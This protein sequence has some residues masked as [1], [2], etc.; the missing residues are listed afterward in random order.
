MFEQILNSA[1]RTQEEFAELEENGWSKAEIEKYKRGYSNG[2][3]SIVSELR[4]EGLLS[5]VE[6]SRIEAAF[7]SKE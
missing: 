3:F 2:F 5:D 7:E 1:G 6:V 4:F